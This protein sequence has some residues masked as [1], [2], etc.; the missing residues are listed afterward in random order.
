MVD[1]CPVVETKER[2][3]MSYL[4]CVFAVVSVVVELDM[5]SPFGYATRVCMLLQAGSQTLGEVARMLL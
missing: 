2:F 4:A 3:L 1:V 5:I